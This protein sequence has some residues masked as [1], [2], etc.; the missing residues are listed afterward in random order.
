MLDLEDSDSEYDSDEDIPKTSK[1]A[2]KKEADDGNMNSYSKRIQRWKESETRL[3]EGFH[4]VDG[5]FILPE[6]L[7]ES[8]YK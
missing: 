5:S 1:R 8:L 6:Y 2:V 4:K 3:S 7:W